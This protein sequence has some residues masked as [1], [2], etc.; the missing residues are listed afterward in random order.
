MKR[1]FSISVFLMLWPL[2]AFGEEQLVSDRTCESL[3]IRMT[4]AHDKFVGG[5]HA[6]AVAISLAAHERLNCPPEDLLE[7]LN[8]RHEPAPNVQKKVSSQ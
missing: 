7:V 4:Q 6:A 3:V 5:D 8:I 2:G 1:L